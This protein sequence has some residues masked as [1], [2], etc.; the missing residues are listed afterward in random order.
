MCVVY[1]NVTFSFSHSDNICPPPSDSAHS[2]QYWRNLQ[3]TKVVVLYLKWELPHPT[4]D[5]M[6]RVYAVAVSFLSEPDPSSPLPDVLQRLFTL[7]NLFLVP[8]TPA[9]FAQE[10]GRKG[11]ESKAEFVCSFLRRWGKE[12]EAS[13]GVS[14]CGFVTLP[15]FKAASAHCWLKGG[16]NTHSNMECAILCFTPLVSSWLGGLKN[17]G[18]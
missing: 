11:R 6:L 9:C 2:Y 5:H 14:L 7:W 10:R 1:V 15:W 16:C 3:L 4:S 8:L 13:S 12:T 18:D 17:N